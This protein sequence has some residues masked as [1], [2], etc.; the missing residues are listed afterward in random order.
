MLQ[1]TH[2]SS[3]TPYFHSNNVLLNMETQKIKINMETQKLESR[4][5]F[6]RSMSQITLSFKIHATDQSLF[7]DPCH[8]SI[9][10][11]LHISSY[12]Y[13]TLWCLP[14][15]TY[16]TSYI[17]INNLQVQW[18]CSFFIIIFIEKKIDRPRSLLVVEPGLETKSPAFNSEAPSSMH[19]TTP[20]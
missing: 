7:Q 17:F 13:D 16:I 1:N 20:L 19:N 8:R 4:N 18:G 12:I 15:F 10:L 14:L 5:T 3:Y 6:P 9:S 11:S 2:N